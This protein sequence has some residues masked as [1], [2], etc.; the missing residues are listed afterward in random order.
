MYVYVF[1]FFLKKKKDVKLPGSD[2]VQEHCYPTGVVHNYSTKALEHLGFVRCYAASYSDKTDF[3]DIMEK[4]P[5]YIGDV[6]FNMPLF[7]GA[8]KSADCEDEIYMGS[9]TNDNQLLVYL[10]NPINLGEISTLENEETFQIGGLPIVSW[11]GFASSPTVD[12]AEENC[13]Q[14]NP[15]DDDR[16]CWIMDHRKGGYRAGRNV[17]LDTNKNWHKVLYYSNRSVDYYSVC[18]YKNR[19]VPLTDL[20]ILPVI[21]SADA[22]AQSAVS[23]PVLTLL[24]LAGVILT[25]LILL[26]SK[27]KSKL[28]MKKICQWAASNKN[29][30]VS[31]IV[32]EEYKPLLVTTDN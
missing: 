20:G 24:C 10:G 11:L 15:D 14:F 16:L 19:Y 25:L 32:T 4:C 7:F 2:N 9:F 28:S 6:D 22:K 17:D 8:C 23:F 26:C 30:M 13:D 31:Q 18:G 27:H 3:T 21:I 12:F 29:V 1:F 5:V